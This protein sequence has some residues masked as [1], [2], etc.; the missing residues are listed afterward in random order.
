MKAL[1]VGGAGFVGKH[2]IKHLSNVCQWDVVA[3]KLSNQNFEYNFPNVSMYDLDILKYEHIIKLLKNHR[4]DYIF[5]LAAQS[6]VALSWQ[7]PLQTVDINI[8]G[9][10]NILEAV[11]SLDY[12]PTILLIGS[13]EEYGIPEDPEDV[14]DERHILRP[15]NIYAATKAFQNMIGKIY[16]DAYKL[17]IIMVRAFNHIGPG[18]LPNFVVSDFCKQVV[19]IEKGLRDPIIYVGNL[20]AY[21]DFTDVRDIVRIYSQLATTNKWG[22]TYNV[23]SGEVISIHEMLNKILSLSKAKIEVVIDKNKFRPVD[24]NMIKPNIDKLTRTIDWKPEYSIEDTLEDVL[25][26]WRKNI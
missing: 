4:P 23:G 22:E 8:K 9:T 12:Q 5:H 11:R 17:N 13:G 10:I 7:N 2:L 1:V 18:Q 15:T 26:Y 25:N 3:T 16:V 20:L 21:R 6:S 24:V 14:I 19:E